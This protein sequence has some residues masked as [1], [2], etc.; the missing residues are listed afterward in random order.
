[1][2]RRLFSILALSSSLLIVAVTAVP[3]AAQERIGVLMLHGKN[4]GSNMDPNFGLMKGNFERQGWLV[5]FPDMPWSRGRYLDGG[6]DQA[7]AEIASHIKTLRDQGATK[8]V[9]AGHSMGVPTGMAYAVRG[10]DVDALVQLAPGHTPVGYYNQPW[11]KVV[12]ESIDE[13]RALVAAG[14]GDTRERFSDINQ[15]RQL[16]VVSTSKDYLSYFD[17]TS[18]AEMS[19]TAP[20]IPAKVAVMTAVGEK[21]PLFRFI[22]SYYID[23]LPA[24]SKNKFLE[25]SGGHLDTPR[26]SN[27][28]VIA[29]IK[30]AVAP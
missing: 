13:A 11:G 2:L 25:V 29:W 27:D 6:L 23:K 21:D 28:E 12:R 8:I 19:I 26:A 4:P 9:I 17:P 3:A 15:G 18:D 24:N 30:A 1:M 7:M 14:R 16:P 22:K 20:R 10:G 5:A